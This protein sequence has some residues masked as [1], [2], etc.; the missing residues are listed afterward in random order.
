MKQ[1]AGIIHAAIADTARAYNSA[2]DP[3]CAGCRPASGTQP[4]GGTHA[5]RDPMVLR[6]AMPELRYGRLQSAW[7]VRLRGIPPPVHGLPPVSQSIN[8]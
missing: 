1:G 4:G 7:P 3:S 2:A 5:M 8:L 6:I